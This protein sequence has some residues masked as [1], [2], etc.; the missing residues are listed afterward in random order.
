MTGH[1][2]H[3][4]QHE[5]H[6]TQRLDKWLW[7]ARMA[8]SRTLAAQLVQDG[9]VRVNRAKVTKPAQTVR[10]DDV[11]T[12]VVRGNIQV[13]KVLAPG[14]RRGPPAEARQL[15]EVLSAS[16]SPAPVQPGPVQRARGS[17]RPSKRDRRLLD[18]ISEHD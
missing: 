4:D 6:S 1:D 13:L 7:F 11:L 2:E 15:Y 3:P 9:K 18:R 8:K 17:G 5:G 12:I 16:G 10:P 14:L